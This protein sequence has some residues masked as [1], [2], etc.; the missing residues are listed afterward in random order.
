MKLRELTAADASAAATIEADLFADET[1]WSRDVFLVQFAH[2]YTF[3]VGAFEDSGDEDDD[4]EGEQLVGYAGLAKLGPADD[5]EFEV[6]TVAVAREHQGKGLG[7]VLMDQLTNA[8]DMYDGQM[9]LEVRTDNEA[10]LG[11]YERYGFNKIGVRKGYYQPAGADAYTM[12]R[13][14]ISEREACDGGEGPFERSSR[15]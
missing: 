2:P 13:P 11:L 7:R 15:Q 10:A 5:P 1:P 14:S 4:A 12:M 9:F 3:Y 8:A 6:Y